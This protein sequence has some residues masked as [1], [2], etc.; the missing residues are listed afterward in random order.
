MSII[1]RDCKVIKKSQS[2]PELFNLEFV[3]SNIPADVNLVRVKEALE[4]KT[5]LKEELLKIGKYWA[6]YANDLSLR[7]D[8]VWLDGRLVI[9]LPL[10]V[11]VESRIHYYHHGKR[12]MFEAARDVWYPYMYRSLAAKATYCQQCTEAGKNLKPLLPKGDMGKVPEPRE[13]N[14]C[15]QLDFWGPINYLN[16]SK[17]YVLVATDRFSRWPSAMVTTTNTS[18]KVLKFLN[19]YISHHGVPRK[20]HVDQGS[21]FTSNKFKSFCN[22]E[23][24]ELMYSP[25]NDHRGTGSVERTIGSLKNFVLTYA[26][27][28]GHK[29]LE[30]MV[31]KALGALR[32]SKNAT[33]KLTPFE[34]H[35]GREAN[36][37]LRNL[38]KKPSL[39]NLNWKNVLKQKCLCLDET[40]PEMSKVAFPQHSNWEERSDLTY[41]PT[42]R[43]APIT[44]DSDQQMDACP[45]EGSEVGPQIQ[46]SG[47]TGPNIQGSGGGRTLYQRTTSKTLNRYK[48]LKSNVISESEHTLKLKNGSVLRKSAVASKPKPD[49][50][51]KRK[52]ATLKDMLASAKKGAVVSPKSKRAKTTRTVQVATFESDS[53]DTE[54]DQPLNIPAR[55]PVEM[56]ARREAIA[57]GQGPSGSTT[58]M[59]GGTGA[60]A[61]SR[62]TRAKRG[63]GG[64]RKQAKESQ[65]RPALVARECLVNSSQEEDVESGSQSESSGTRRSTRRRKPVDK[66]GGVMIETIQGAEQTGKHPG[67]EGK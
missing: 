41:A 57:A 23:G 20:I 10:Q 47:D 48:L 3:A 58:V 38:T 60:K 53:S 33:T 44:L 2:L 65:E 64:Q 17:K 11:P 8:C 67:G 22:E 14:E 42:L 25:V 32:F 50:P 7:D 1:P 12:N 16:E 28:K 66:M 63:K 35:H 37:V 6:Q 36:T 9:P 54:D 21:C 24:I 45:R 62:V 31:D 61:K 52:P 26:T 51:K 46:G 19:K 56:L 34:A 29:S 4:K 39:K 15:L 5:N 18:D 27:E 59:E 49:L 30:S 55:L 40:D 43:R 13:P